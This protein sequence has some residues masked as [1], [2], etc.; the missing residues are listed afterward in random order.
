[1]SVTKFDLMY[2]GKELKQNS[3]GS[4]SFAYNR[5]R[6]CGNNIAVIGGG[7]ASVERFCTSV[8]VI[9]GLAEDKGSIR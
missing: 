9:K 5:E 7:T 4:F 6:H 2:T 8:L 1:M 3:F